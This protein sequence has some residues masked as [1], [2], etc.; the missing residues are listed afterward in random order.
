MLAAFAA[1][2]PQKA[3]FVQS[4]PGEHLAA[5]AHVVCSGVKACRVCSWNAVER[6][7]RAIAA[8]ETP[9]SAGMLATFATGTLQNADFM[10]SRPEKRPFP[11]ERLPRLQLECRRRPISCNRGR[12]NAPFGRNALPRLQLECR[13][14]LVLCNR[15][16]RIASFGR[17]HSLHD[18]GQASA[19][20][21][22][23]GN[24]ARPGQFDP[25]LGNSTQPSPIRPYPAYQL[26]A[27]CFR[28]SWSW[29]SWR[30]RTWMPASWK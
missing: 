11:P 10:Q 27:G 6:R 16:R 5:T 22:A 21:P 17:K 18:Y 13:R 24:S 15:G 1:G 4:R 26:M 28:A 14:R 2:V 8:E 30:R 9:P 7:F 23:L 20:R 3:G 25:D 29:S 19:I 12:E